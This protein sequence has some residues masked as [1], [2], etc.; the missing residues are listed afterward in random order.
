MTSMHIRFGHSSSVANVCVRVLFVR[1]P[2]LVGASRHCAENGSLVVFEEGIVPF[3]VRRAFLVDASGGAVRGSHAHLDCWQA[4]F[5]VLGTLEV[6]T[7]WRDGAQTFTLLEGGFGLV[8]P[9]LVWATQRY[10][11]VRTISIVVCSEEYD[12]ADYVR[13]FG[14]YRKLLHDQPDAES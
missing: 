3:P 13:S 10:L 11:G 5:V 7:I 9:P 4:L 1:S 8:L 2:F 14:A 6:D 12:E